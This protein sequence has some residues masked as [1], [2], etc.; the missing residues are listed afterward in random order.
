MNGTDEVRDES[1]RI[2]VQTVQGQPADRPFGMASKIDQ[3]GRL[4]IPGWCGNNDQLLI[5][6]IIQDFQQ[7]LTG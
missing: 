7:P 2:L 4:A 5:K 1:K 3:Q 6:Q